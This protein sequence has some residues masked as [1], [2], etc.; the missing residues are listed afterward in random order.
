MSDKR[1]FGLGELGE[2]VRAMSRP[3]AGA[4]PPPYQGTALDRPN[5]NRGHAISAFA[6]EDVPV[7]DEPP[8]TPE[9]EVAPAI[10]RGPQALLSL[11]IEA[12]LAFQSPSAKAAA[13]ELLATQPP[14][15]TS[16]APRPNNPMTSKPANPAA[17]RSGLQRVLN[18][19]RSSFPLVQKLLPLLEG[20]VAAT[21]GALVAHQFTPPQPPVNLEPVERELAEVR[22]S[23]R[24]LRGQVMEQATALKRIDD[25]LDRVREAT[26]RNTLE[27]Q[28]LV[29][30]LHSTGKRITTFAIIGLVLLAVSLGLNIYLL[31]LQVRHIVP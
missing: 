14:V 17:P 10:L 31:L 15:T 3:A 12:E 20:N 19:A 4:Q 16:A 6:R 13:A 18:A 1:T 23:N 22:N 5:P 7:I 26:D 29:E 27:Q 21:V 8:I 9:Q 30:K 2:R 24:E 28:E 11:P 25:H